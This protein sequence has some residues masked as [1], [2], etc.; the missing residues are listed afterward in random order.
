MGYKKVLVTFSD[1]RLIRSR[2]RFLNESKS[3]NYY[4]EVIALDENDLAPE[5]TDKFR[6]KL[7]PNVRGFGYW[8][9]KPQAILQVLTNLNDGD[10]LQYADVGFSVNP[11]GI[12]RLN[13]YFDR[14]SQSKVGI[15]GFQG[16]RPEF[17]M[18]DDGREIPTWPD[19]EWTKG[20][21][22]DYFGVRDNAEITDTPTVQ[23]GL[24]FVRKCTEAESILRQ[25]LSV[26]SNSFHLADDSPSIS[27]NL[28]GFRE[29]RHDQSIFS[30]LAKLNNIDTYSSNEF[31]FPQRFSSKG[32]W[33]A[34]S[35]S[36]FHATRSLDFGFWG[37]TKHK[38][39][40]YFNAFKVNNLKVSFK[41]LY[42][43]IRKTLAKS[44]HDS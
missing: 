9:W 34:L 43:R 35:F 38:I 22:F 18:V 3:L 33:E 32:D 40:F 12:A 11:S 30:I 17:P 28:E 36:P 24:L 42:S 20:D 37:N 29:H 15:V 14:A 2:N 25:W 4:D 7:K 44:P 26:Y 1:S 16:R 21:L 31:W 5:F 13:D 23:A 27:P 10:V 39:R 8:V 41:I 19:R 6:N